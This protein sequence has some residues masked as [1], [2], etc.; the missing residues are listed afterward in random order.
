MSLPFLIGGSRE[1]KMPTKKKIPKQ[2]C[3]PAQQMPIEDEGYVVYRYVVVP[4]RYL[5]GWMDAG[6][7]S[8]NNGFSEIH[9]YSSS[10]L[11]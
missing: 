1:K 5:N 9:L 2:A 10:F 6:S 7:K 8:I 3:L 4:A 11:G